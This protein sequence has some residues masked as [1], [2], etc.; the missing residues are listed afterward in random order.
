ME[1]LVAEKTR[2]KAARLLRE[3]STILNRAQSFEVRKGDI[4]AFFYFDENATRRA[5]STWVDNARRSSE[6]RRTGEY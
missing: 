5:I 6:L 1:A 3:P 2:K 4:R